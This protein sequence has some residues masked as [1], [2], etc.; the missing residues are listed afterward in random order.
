[1]NVITVEHHRICTPPQMM[2]DTATKH[3]SKQHYRRQ[4]L[5]DLWS[6]LLFYQFFFNNKEVR[7]HLMNKVISFT[8][9]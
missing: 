3:Y 4:T 9:S 1:M 2:D 5:T 7:G 8:S 6:V